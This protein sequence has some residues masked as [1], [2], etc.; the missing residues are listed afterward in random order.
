M[1]GERSS[2]QYVYLL[3]PTDKDVRQLKADLLRQMAYRTTGS[4]ARAFLMSEALAL[5]GKVAIPR[6]VPPTPEIIADSPD[7]FVNF[8]RVRI[9]PRK[10]QDTDKVIQFVFTD[11]ENKAVG[12]HVRRGIVEYIPVPADYYRKPDYVIELGSEAWAA[13]YLSSTD[14]AKA[15]AA[16]KIKLTKGFQ[17]DVAGLLDLFDKLV[18]T[19]NY[20]IP[21]LED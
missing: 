2:I 12:L 18:P 10:A 16:G 5:E 1:P 7:T 17:G 3:D 4:I 13:L 19:R 15:V 8:F 20:K 6:L 11:K 14:L 21:P 9:D